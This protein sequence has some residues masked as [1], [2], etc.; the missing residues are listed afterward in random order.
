MASVPAP[1]GELTTAEILQLIAQIRNGFV[2]DS[3]AADASGVARDANANYR[4]MSNK[5]QGYADMY[6]KLLEA[7]SG[8]LNQ[9]QDVN[10][11]Y[12]RNRA[13]QIFSAYSGSVDRANAIAAS[14][15]GARLAKSGMGNSSAADDGRQGLTRQ[16]S[17]VYNALQEKARQRA[18]DELK[19]RQAQ[20]TVNYQAA[21][22]GLNGSLRMALENSRQYATDAGR[23]STTANT[24]RGTA[25]NNVLDT[26]VA[27]RVMGGIDSAVKDAG[28]YGALLK[29][30]RAGLFNEVTPKEGAGNITNPRPGENSYGFGVQQAPE[31]DWGSMFDSGPQPSQEDAQAW[32]NVQTDDSWYMQPSF[33]QAYDY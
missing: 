10:D 25:I 17:D 3:Q 5:T 12:L 13:D 15:L 16:Y 31:W 29:S 4:E 8:R 27:G 28:G 20:D 11:E 14:Q 21:A 6:G 30:L 2:T 22:Q 19:A 33:E 23:A 18:F 32:H 1:T 24:A 9:P 26:G 7:L